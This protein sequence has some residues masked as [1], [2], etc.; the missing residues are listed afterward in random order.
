MVASLTESFTVIEFLVGL[1]C[2]LDL[3]IEGSASLLSP[4]R[5][6]TRLF[7]TRVNVA[8]STANDYCFSCREFLL[9][10]REASWSRWYLLI[11]NQ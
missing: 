8:A 11:V 4:D 3:E 2:D 1:N 10:S 5:L 7:M 9:E 6:E